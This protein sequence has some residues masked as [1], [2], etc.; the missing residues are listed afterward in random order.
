LYSMLEATFILQAFV[1]LFLIVDPV[2]A[3]P[4]FMALME[5]LPAQDRAGVIR[6][7]VS[8]ACTVL[9]VFTVFGNAI[10][11]LLGISMYSFR[12]AG[13]ILL[14][15]IAVEMLFGKKTR[16]EVSEDTV[17]EREEDLAVTPM[18]VPLLTGPG[19]ITSGIMLYTLAPT[20]ADKAVLTVTVVAVFAVCYVILRNAEPVRKTLG[21]TGAKVLMRLMGLLL[22]AIAVQFIISGLREA[23]PALLA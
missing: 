20:A 18:A 12:I 17:A 7:A 23:F 11:A 6:R 21:K 19:A 2:G 3:V 1:T 14:L 13:G 10:F 5:G 16:T 15:I 4:L 8:I 9:L 22:S